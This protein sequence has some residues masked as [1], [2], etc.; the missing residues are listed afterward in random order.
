MNTA[1]S[2][3]IVQNG[4]GPHSSVSPD[5]NSFLSEEASRFPSMDISSG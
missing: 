3:S 1:P 4:K 2:G 5:Q